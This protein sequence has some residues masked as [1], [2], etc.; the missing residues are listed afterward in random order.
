MNKGSVFFTAFLAGLAS[1]AALYARNVEY[2]PPVNKLTFADSFLVVGW[3]LNEAAVDYDVSRAGSPTAPIT[4][5]H[6]QSF[7][8]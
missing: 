8:F 7:E 5:E 3:L 1:P 4:V 2:V 6:Q